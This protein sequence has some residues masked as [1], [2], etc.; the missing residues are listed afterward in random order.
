MMKALKLALCQI[1]IS[2]CALGHSVVNFGKLFSWLVFRY[3]FAINSNL[4]TVIF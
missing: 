3:F 1:L 2:C 4:A